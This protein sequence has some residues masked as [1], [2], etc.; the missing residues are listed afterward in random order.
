MVISLLTPQ[1]FAIRTWFCNCAQYLCLFRIDVECS[2]SIHDIQQRCYFS[3][4]RLLLSTFHIGIKILFL[5]LGNNTGRLVTWE[6]PLRTDSASWKSLESFIQFTSFCSFCILPDN[7]KIVFWSSMS[8]PLA[9]VSK[10]ELW[11]F[12]NS[13]ISER[14]CWW[15]SRNFICC[16]HDS[17]RRIRRSSSAWA[18]WS[19]WWPIFS[20]FSSTII[21]LCSSSRVLICAFELFRSSGCP[22]RSTILTVWMSSENR[23][24][25]NLPIDRHFSPSG[26]PDPS[27]L[28]RRRCLTDWLTCPLV[29][30]NRLVL[31]VP[32]WAACRVSR[33]PCPGPRTGSWRR[34]G[35]MSR[36]ARRRS[37]CWA[38]NLLWSGRH[39]RCPHSFL[40]RSIT[41]FPWRSGCR[42]QGTARSAGGRG[43]RQGRTG[44]S[45]KGISESRW[46]A[47]GYDRGWEMTRLRSWANEGW[48]DIKCERERSRARSTHGVHHAIVEVNI[49]IGV[50]LGE[51]L[52]ARVVVDAV[53]GLALSLIAHVVVVFVVAKIA[54]NFAVWE[55]YT[56]YTPVGDGELL[57]AVTEFWTVILHQI[58]SENHTS[59]NWPN[60]RP[61]GFPDLSVLGPSSR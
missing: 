50:V 46:C 54:W 45:K 47:H 23:V 21:C 53:I 34:R 36:C 52:V 10:V 42:A 33:H 12:R 22:D 61:S 16:R 1:K 6:F 5:C 7:S 27:N 38:H 28:N 3:P 17:S 11:N 8:F 59:N 2:P 43:K 26:C 32:L 49:V 58:N 25:Q 14:L 39:S 41:G 4:N 9:I 60:H 40:R 24:T 56:L 29:R 35:L 44:R 15:A 20:Q 13:S 51:V 57:L 48:D 30:S 19:S 31:G 18:A 55:I 37:G